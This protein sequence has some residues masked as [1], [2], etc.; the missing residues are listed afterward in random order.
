[1]R[2]DLDAFREWTMFILNMRLAFPIPVDEARAWF[3]TL[4]DVPPLGDA[5]EIKSGKESEE[6][7]SVV[8]TKDGR[9]SGADG[10][11]GN[12]VAIA[13]GPNLPYA[14]WIDHLRA[15]VATLQESLHDT[16]REEL[17]EVSLRTQFHMPVACNIYK[18]I[19]DTCFA[20]SPLANLAEDDL[21]V[22]NS[23]TI[24]A[25]RRNEHRFL[26]RLRVDANQTV[27]EI[28]AG[29]LDEKNNIIRIVLD[30]ERE[31]SALGNL[32]LEEEATRLAEA[33]Y[34]LLAGE[35]LDRIIVPLAPAQE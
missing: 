30:T 10:I 9:I 11:S 24:A 20:S 3:R 19:A 21:I 6:G 32:P 18:A 33:S 27:S 25:L 14:E 23:L 5:R 2:R 22:G 4:G 26:W 12:V 15:A 29:N 35:L 34:D 31:P 28:I 13:G 1:M 17:D 7:I 16:A 8:W